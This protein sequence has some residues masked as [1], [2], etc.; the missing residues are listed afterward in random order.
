MKNILERNQEENK[1]KTTE[2]MHSNAPRSD[3]SLYQ[4][5]RLVPNEDTSMTK[6]HVA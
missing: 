3:L 6:L 5:F 2:I 1:E 4:T